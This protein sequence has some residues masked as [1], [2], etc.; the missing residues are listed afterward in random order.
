MLFSF[1]ILWTH[2]THQGYS[3]FL[4]WVICERTQRNAIKLGTPLYSTTPKKIVSPIHNKIDQIWKQK[5]VI[6]KMIK[7]KGFNPKIVLTGLL[8]S[9]H[10]SDVGTFI[11]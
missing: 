2:R 11:M 8:A 6:R 9:L 3:R 4:R 1:T 5:M 7:I 10:F